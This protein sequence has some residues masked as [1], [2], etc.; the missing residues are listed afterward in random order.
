[1]CKQKLFSP[2]V[3]MIYDEHILCMQD[4]ER[5]YIFLYNVAAQKLRKHICSTGA[6]KTTTKNMLVVGR[7]E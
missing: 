3:Y 7:Q 5:L 1:M 2:I 6:M 4:E